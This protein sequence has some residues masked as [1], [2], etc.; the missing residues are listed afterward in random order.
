MV[1]REAIDERN[2]SALEG[3]ANKLN[4]VRPTKSLFKGFSQPRYRLTLLTAPRRPCIM[5]NNGASSTLPSRPLCSA[6]NRCGVPSGSDTKSSNKSV[7]NGYA[8]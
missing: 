8:I 6:T 7:R 5:S 1:D 4:P 2:H 3:E